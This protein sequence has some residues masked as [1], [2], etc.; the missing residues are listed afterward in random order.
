MPAGVGRLEL[1]PWSPHGPRLLVEGWVF[2]TADEVEKLAAAQPVDDA[3]VF[4][5]APDRAHQLHEVARQLLA[6]HRDAPGDVAGV[7]DRRF[8]CDLRADRR[9]DAVGAD[10]R[11]A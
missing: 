7:L 2:G 8:A 10:Q 3:M 9:L 1:F 4:G 6:R 5:P 11:V